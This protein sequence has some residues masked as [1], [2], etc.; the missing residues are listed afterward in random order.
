[1]LRLVR[2]RCCLREAAVSASGRREPCKST[3]TADI[4]NGPPAR[5][6]D[7]PEARGQV[8]GFTARFSSLSESKVQTTTNPYETPRRRS[9][10]TT[11]W[12]RVASPCAF[13]APPFRDAPARGRRGQ[14]VRR[15][16]PRLAAAS[17]HSCAGAP[18]AASPPH[19]LQQPTS[20]TQSVGLLTHAR[21]ETKAMR[22]F[23]RQRW[24]SR[25]PSHF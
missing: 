4:G 20:E 25:R 5:L 17:C 12:R 8:G 15:A 22:R 10:H 24:C 13:P 1:M 16:V 23:Q 18:A 9:C 21:D 7:D 11:Q 14:C 2:A 3:P 6:C 19:R